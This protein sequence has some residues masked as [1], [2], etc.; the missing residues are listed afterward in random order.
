MGNLLTHQDQ[1][2]QYSITEILKIDRIELKKG[3]TIGIQHQV[4]T[5]TE[6]DFILIIS[7][8]YGRSEF[9]TLD[10]AKAAAKQGKWQ[11]EYGH[12]PNRP[13]GA[14]NGKILIDH[15]PIRKDELAG[16]YQ[17]RKAFD[18]KEAGVF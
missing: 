12:I 11:V 2:G 6:D 18:Q 17:W 8:S 14:A 7:N 4:F 3:D 1:D 9:S 16:Y 15:Q 10:D 5:A 13:P